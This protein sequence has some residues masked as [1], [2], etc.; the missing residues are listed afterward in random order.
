MNLTKVESKYGAPMGRHTH[1]AHG[2]DDLEFEVEYVPMVDDC[3]D[4]GG[5]YWGSGSLWAYRAQVDLEELVFNFVRADDREAA[6]AHI[7]SEYPEATFEKENG[8]IIQQTIDSLRNF[9][10]QIDNADDDS[11]EYMQSDTEA[12][13]SILDDMLAEIKE[14]NDANT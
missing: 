7:R 12:H 3:Y 9:L 10:A 8:S 11:A 13:I 4:V 1:D 2:M 5:A 14:C 6:M